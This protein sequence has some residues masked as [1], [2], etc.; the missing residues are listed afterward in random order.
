M[1]FQNGWVFPI[2]AEDVGKI[3]GSGV[4]L[5]GK[6]VHKY[7]DEKLN[8]TIKRRVPMIVSEKV[9]TN[10]PSIDDVYKKKCNRQYYPFVY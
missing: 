7:V 10:S 3:E 1:E 2:L 6:V 8:T 9:H 4:I 5:A